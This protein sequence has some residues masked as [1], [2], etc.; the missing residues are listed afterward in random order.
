MSEKKKKNM[1]DRIPGIDKPAN[2]FMHAI[3]EQKRCDENDED[4]QFT[5]EVYY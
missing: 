5:Q 2:E 1:I 3:T 4:G